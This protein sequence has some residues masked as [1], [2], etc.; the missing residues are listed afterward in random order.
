MNNF[1]KKI[2][3][4]LR[5]SKLGH[6]HRF[7]RYKYR[8]E[9]DSIRYIQ[10]LDLNGKSVLD[11][12]ANRGVYCYFLSR[13]VGSQGT[14]TAFEPQPECMDTI[15]RVRVMF[16]IT[17]LDARN[18]GLSDECAS[19]TIHRGKPEHGSA[20]LHFNSGEHKVDHAI[21]ASVVTLDSISD[22]LPR[23]ISFIK[24]DIESHE[25]AMFTGAR[26]TLIQDKP[27]ILVEIHQ[28]QMQEVNGVLSSYG[29]AGSFNVGKHTHPICEYDKQPYEKGRRRRNYIFTAK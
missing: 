9:P 6:V 27:T 2:R 22:T 29:Y 7:M 12:G 20:S 25:L 23:P 5:K 13:C 15:E 8:T 16:K 14:V 10:S 28:D 1:L 18:Y 19:V 3:M 21:Q 26:A 24:C 11:I 4:S 17:N